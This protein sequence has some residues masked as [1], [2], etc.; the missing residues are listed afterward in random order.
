MEVDSRVYIT[1]D[2]GAITVNID[3]ERMKISEYNY[4]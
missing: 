2:S 3:G 4:R 1:K